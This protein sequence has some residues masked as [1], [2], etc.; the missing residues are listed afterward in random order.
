MRESDL[1]RRVREIK[2]LRNQGLLSQKE[3]YEQ[4]LAALSILASHENDALTAYGSQSQIESPVHEQGSGEPGLRL[5]I[6]AIGLALVGG[7]L[8]VFGAVVQEVQAGGGILLAFTGAPLIEEAMKPAGI[9][10]LLLR[11]PQA[12][13]S[14]LHTAWLTAL[15]GLCFG[16]IEAFVYV[17]LYN[18]DGSSDFVLYRFTAPLAMHA[19]A[20]FIVGLGLSRAIIDWAAGRQRF[21]KETRNFYLAGA[22]LH[23]AF[24]I[25]VVT[26]A[27]AG[28]LD[29]E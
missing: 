7:V 20:S 12:V 14:Q 19:V 23:A 28:Y 18:P 11:W 26:L 4:H 13:R 6:I 29:F 25:T 22:G 24:N 21:P 1:D 15:S 5:D 9:Y 10:I 8:G 2:S 27:F 3:A 17:E 16:L